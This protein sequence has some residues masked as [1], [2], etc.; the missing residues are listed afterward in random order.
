MPQWFMAIYFS[1]SWGGHLADI[2]YNGRRVLAVLSELTGR[3]VSESAEFGV[4]RSLPKS[5]AGAIQALSQ[6]KTLSPQKKD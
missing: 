6:R 2:M 4:S 1:S 5:E 3:S